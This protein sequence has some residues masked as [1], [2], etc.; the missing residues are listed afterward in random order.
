M[1]LT[2]LFVAT[3]IVGC[4][5]TVQTDDQDG[6]RNRKSAAYLAPD[7]GASDRGH[8][9]A[10]AVALCAFCHSEV[11]W[12]AEG[13]PPK[14][15]TV[16]GGRSPFGP[17]M[18]WLTSPN[19]TPDRETGAGTW[20]DEQF[21]AALRRGISHDGRTLFP[22]MPYNAYHAMSDADATSIV[23]FLRSL[24]PVKNRLPATQIPEELK[25]TLFPLPPPGAVQA[26]DRSPTAKYGEYLARMALCGQCHTPKDAKGKPVPGMELAGG[27]R[28]KGPWGDVASLNITP[29]ATG[30]EGVTEKLFFSAMKTG[31]VGGG[32]RLNAI[33]PWGY[34]QHM[35][36]EDLRAI[37]LYV[38]SVK[39]VPH[40]VDNSSPP[41]PCK[42]CGGTH[43][44][45]EKNH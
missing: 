7:T 21:G 37:Y 25:S 30:M 4:S 31:H 6:S 10:T 9:L 17:E 42:K 24:P 23:Q 8:Y 41:T 43:G 40:F 3:W 19:I 12:K 29:D 45:G 13:F 28:L 5:A 20:T 36:D 39:P 27:A 32:D 26:P 1:R 18:P 15:G 16:G 2:A 11:D 44:L 38:K 34:Y 35:T 22:L 33:M 14:A